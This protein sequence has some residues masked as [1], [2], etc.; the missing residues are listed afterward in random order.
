MSGDPIWM[1]ALLTVHIAA[2]AACLLIVPL[3]LSVTKGG[4]AHRRWGRI[5]FWSMAALAA[6]ALAMALYR[7][8][9]FLALI[10]VL[11]FYL[12]FSGYRVVQLRRLGRAGE[13]VDWLAALAA[14]AACGTLV[15]FALYRPHWVQNMG[16]V[17]IVL[18]AIGCWAAISDL[19]RFLRRPGQ[20]T[21][22]VAT[23]LGRFL[24]SYIAAWT[25]LSAV[26]LSQLLPHEFL[27]VWLWPSIVGI[28][29]ITLTAAYYRRKF[30][31]PMPA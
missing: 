30:A 17:A 23:H 12:V 7:P 31:R 20:D 2:G 28:P 5:Y 10:S 25:A 14:A 11:S 26:V 6:T 13:F 9:F 27:V 22:W 8:V 4:P 24:G 1:K 3:V 19:R 16:P 21:H 15:V 18:G 29:I